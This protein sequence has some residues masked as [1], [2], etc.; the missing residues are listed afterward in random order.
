[1]ECFSP[2]EAF[3]IAPWGLVFL[4]V[5]SERHVV[6]MFLFFDLSTAWAG[7]VHLEVSAKLADYTVDSVTY[8]HSREAKN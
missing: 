8:Q 2:S 6:L 7:S 1:M 4:V 5:W 3:R